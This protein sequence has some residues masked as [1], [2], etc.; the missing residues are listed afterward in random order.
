MSL[1]ERNQVNG[2][3]AYNRMKYNLHEAMQTQFS[4]PALLHHE[5]E[6]YKC[7]FWSADYWLKQSQYGM[8][9]RNDQAFKEVY[10]DCT[11]G[12]ILELMQAN[13]SFQLKISF[14]RARKHW[15]L[16]A[17]AIIKIAAIR[18]RLQ[19]QD[20]KYVTVK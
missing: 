20:D 14:R 13:K 19:V 12:E 17:Y 10:Q 4:I 1:S 6:I 8:T 18:P 15:N 16:P 2:H 3:V 5:L 11:R 7:L 9:I